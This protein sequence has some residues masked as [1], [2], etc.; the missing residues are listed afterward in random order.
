MKTMRYGYGLIGVTAL[1]L[2]TGAWAESRVIAVA[3]FGTSA[4][5]GTPDGCTDLLWHDTDTGEL[6]IHYMAKDG[7]SVSN[8]VGSIDQVELR[9]GG[10]GYYSTDSLVINSEGTGGIGLEAELE[11][12]GPIAEITVVDPGRDYENGTL[13]E[14]DPG[15]AGGDGC[16]AIT[17]VADGGADS[18]QLADVAVLS[19]GFGYEPGTVDPGTGILE[20]RPHLLV[21]FP[22]IGGDPA[23][24][25]CY[26]DET[27]RIMDDASGFGPGIIDNGSGFIGTPSLEFV[28]P[29]IGATG[30]EFQ[31]YLYGGI[32]SVLVAVNGSGYTSDPEWVIP[33]ENG[34]GAQIATSRGPGA[35]HDVKVTSTGRNYVLPPSILAVGEGIGASFEAIINEGGPQPIARASTDQAIYVGGGLDVDAHPG[36]FDGDG[37]T[38]LIFRRA[39]RGEVFLWIMEDGVKQDGI[40]LDAI[41]GANWHLIGIGD[42]NFDGIDDVYWWEENVGRICLWYINHPGSPLFAAD[43]PLLD[44]RWGGWVPDSSWRPFSIRDITP[45]HDGPEIL[46]GNVDTGSVVI[47]MRDPEN[48]KFVQ[49]GFYVREPGGALLNAGSSWEPRHFGDFD[50][51][52]FDGDIFWYN[53]DD[54]RT[55]VWRMHLGTV[56]DRNYLSSAAGDAVT[57]YHPVGVS[58]YLVEDDESGQSSMHAHVL[59]R[60]DETSRV[61]NWRMDRS[62]TAAAFGNSGEE[63]DEGRED[64]SGDSEDELNTGV[65]LRPFVVDRAVLMNVDGVTSE[66][67]FTTAG[68]N[69][70]GSSE[71]DLGDFGEEGKD[72]G[73]SDGSSGD[74]F[75]LGAFDPLNPSTWPDGVETA[76]EMIAWLG[77]NIFANDPT[78]W[79]DGVESEAELA[80]WLIQMVTLLDSIG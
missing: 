70:F 40:R 43:R 54:G 32:K 36:D 58:Q 8:M 37:D 31:G 38:D 41:V 45:A 19:S 49:H 15:A 47:R 29:S 21:A 35:V 13:V 20:P 60:Q 39:D 6:I 64:S 78:T 80:T 12:I 42:F 53:K 33:G 74:S 22:P 5:N 44:Y 69:D 16:I 18:G 72:E 48:P 24:V 73:D 11:V 52:R 2:A 3:D 4:S 51:N 66:L 1:A 10:S 50:S 46:W 26:A 65:I 7:L 30:A 23:Y 9:N 68:G 14:L 63:A 59:W 28:I 34:F 71:D 75:D 56:F 55:A 17:T 62:L 76:D 57:S 77:N 25:L 67:D 27:G 79:P 61:V